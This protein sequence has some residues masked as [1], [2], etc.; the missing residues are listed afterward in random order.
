MPQAPTYTPMA[1]DP[2]DRMRQQLA[3]AMMGQ[4]MSTAPAAGPLAALARALQGA[5]G[6]HMM[7]RADTGPAQM[8][9]ALSGQPA[10]TPEMSPAAQNAA[11]ESDMR[12]RAAAGQDP[13]KGPQPGEP[14]FP[15]LKPAAPPQ[16]EPENPYLR[17]VPDEPSVQQ[18]RGRTVGALARNGPIDWQEQ[19]DAPEENYDEDLGNLQILGRAPDGSYRVKD[20]KTG[21]TGTWRP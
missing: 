13:F 19:T 6:A 5:L 4:G 21:R 20:K 10:P 14:A 1:P 15:P 17:H 11:I 16:V 8:A 9:Q 18:A 3:Q 12:M 2:R 7:N